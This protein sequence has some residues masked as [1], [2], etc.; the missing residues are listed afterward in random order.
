LYLV[1]SFYQI[2]GNLLSCFVS[3]LPPLLGASS[4]LIGAIR[5][6]VASVA[7]AR[8]LVLAVYRCSVSDYWLSTAS[9]A[10]GD[11]LRTYIIP[12]STSPPAPLG[13]RPS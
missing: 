8:G 11:V 10:R 13:K 12:E 4:P 2:L 9:L 1:F 7:C 5:G 6:W 3:L